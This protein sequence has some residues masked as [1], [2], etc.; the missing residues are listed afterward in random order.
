[1]Y[2]TSK[3]WPWGLVVALYAASGRAASNDEQQ[4]KT[5]CA[6][7]SQYARAGY[8]AYQQGDMA[9]AVDEYTAQ[10][11]WSEFCRL[12]TKA[13]HTAY[14]NVALALIRSR[15]PLQAKA[16]LSLAAG[17]AQ[18]RTNEALIQPVLD[19]LQPA[20]AATPM[21]VYWRYAGQGV[22]ST[23]TVLPDGDEWKITFNGYYMP[24]MGMYYGPNMGQFSV[25][26]AIDDGKAVYSQRA[27]HGNSACRVN[28]AFTPDALQLNTVSGD[29][30]FG[31]NVHADGAF[32]RVS[33]Y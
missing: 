23:V 17:D 6:K 4:I 25:V 11:G 15:E 14:N 28:M 8:A 32:Q 3:T 30:G 27:G 29:C 5:D 2:R 26:G 12:P 20:L 21:G 7:I 22:W 1:M 18:T 16:W 19:R 9:H 33:L 13:L 10:V 31:M 24:A